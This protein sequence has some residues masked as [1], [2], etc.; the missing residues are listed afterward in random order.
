MDGTKIVIEG[1]EYELR[2]ISFL[3]IKEFGGIVLGPY[4]RAI[5]VRPKKVM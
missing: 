2:H 1:M 3:G 5:I 4:D